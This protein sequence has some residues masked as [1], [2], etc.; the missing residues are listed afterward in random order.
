MRA[1]LSC[2]I[3]VLVRPPAP[4]MSPAI[5]ACPPRVG[6]LRYFDQYLTSTVQGSP[7]RPEDEARRRSEVARAPPAPRPAALL[8]YIGSPSGPYQP[9]ILGNQLLI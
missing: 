7:P 1:P 3:R 5:D 6:P 9:V 8:A 2:S 4:M